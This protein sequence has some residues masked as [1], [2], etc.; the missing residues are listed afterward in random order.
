MK[1]EMANPDVTPR[2]KFVVSGILSRRVCHALSATAHVP[3]ADL[4]EHIRDSEVL[5]QDLMGSNFGCF[6]SRHRSHLLKALLAAQDRDVF[7]PALDAALDAHGWDHIQVVVQ[8]LSNMEAL[9]PDSESHVVAGWGVDVSLMKRLVR[10]VLRRNALGSCSHTLM[11]GRMVKA[12]S[13]TYPRGNGQMERLEGAVGVRAILD[14]YVRIVSSMYATISTTDLTLDA[15]IF[16]SFMRMVH[17][18]ASRCVASSL[19]YH[20]AI[21]YPLPGAEGEVDLEVEEILV[22]AD[23]DADILLEIDRADIISSSFTS[24]MAFTGD[25]WRAC[26]TLDVRFKDEAGVGEGVARDWIGELSILVFYRSG[27]FTPCPE[28]PA[29]VHPN[30]ELPDDS[31]TSSMMEFA[32]RIMGIARRL[33]IPTGVHLS[34]AAVSMIT[35]Q[36]LNLSTLS[37][38]DPVLASSCAA[39]RIMEEEGVDLGTFVSPGIGCELFPGGSLV[40]VGALE[41]PAFADLLAERHIRGRGLCC[42][43]ACTC[44]AEGILCVMATGDGGDFSDTFSQI[45]RMDAE[46]FNATFGGEGLSHVIDVDDWRSHTDISTLMVI[47]PPEDSNSDME[48]ES[49]I[50]SE[51]ESDYEGVIIPD[52]GHA[53]VTHDMTLD[54]SASNMLFQ[55]IGDMSAEDRRKLLRFWIGSFS[56]PYGGFA[57]LSGRLRLVVMPDTGSRG[58]L[59]NAHTCV[60]MLVLPYHATLPDMRASLEFCLV[61]MNFDEN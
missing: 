24:V 2:R 53:L 43:K 39:V 60:R 3:A 4:A 16:E 58:R 38:L 9:Q 29:L 18:D 59:P 56:L 1:P 14:S 17:A 6:S 33:G 50:E 12:A 21:S 25:D 19:S 36:P 22:S 40:P 27:L 15:E 49:E 42:S 47:E 55:I 46:A 51:V 7:F 48:Y 11:A 37:E 61:S 32:G 10:F 5:V 54:A 45:R 44:I 57:A 31:E 8:R 28:D 23:G 52:E 34:S 30:I 20:N 35:L 26:E 41:R 13:E